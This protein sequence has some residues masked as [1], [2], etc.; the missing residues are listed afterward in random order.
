MKRRWPLFLCFACWLIVL[1]FPALRQMLF[2]Q[3]SGRSEVF[4]PWTHGPFT[5]GTLP[6]AF[7]SLWSSN[8]MQVKERFPDDPRV[9]A[10]AIEEG[11]G[12]RDNDTRALLKDYDALIRRFPQ[13]NWLIARRLIRTIEWMKLNRMGGEFSD[14]FVENNRAKGIPSPERYKEPPNYTPK[15]LEDALEIA[16]LGAEREPDNAFYDWLQFYLLMMNWRDKEAWPL[17]ARGSHKKD[18]NMHG[19]EW[20]K[21]RIA[22][23]E[24]ELGR[25]LL[26]EEKL[27]VGGSTPNSIFS[28]ERALGRIVEWEGLKAGRRRGDHSEALQIYTDM[29]RLQALHAKRSYSIIES[30]VAQALLSLALDVEGKAVRK[31][32]TSQQ[33]ESAEYR[34]RIS[35]RKFA[36]YATKHGRPDLADEITH[37]R[38]A[39]GKQQDLVRIQVRSGN[40][41]NGLT[42]RPLINSITLWWASEILLL[43][44]TLL[45]TLWLGLIAVVR[46]LGL[47]APSISLRDLVL[48]TL[49]STLMAVCC[50]IIPL[51]GG[52]GWHTTY[53]MG[54]S[55]VLG[56]GVK[57]QGENL[58]TL[59]LC[60]VIMPPLIASWWC[61]RVTQQRAARLTQKNSAHLPSR[62][63]E[64]L[65]T[66][67]FAPYVMNFAMLVMATGTLAWWLLVMLKNGEDL[68][69]PDTSGLFGE[70]L[71][72][73]TIT[74]IHPLW[75]LASFAVVLLAARLRP[76][77]NALP[78][79]KPLVA[80]RLHWLHQTL[81]ALLVTGSVSYLLLFALSLPQRA[82]A[83]AQ[84][85]QLI[86]RGELALAREK[87]ARDTGTQKQ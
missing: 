31:D 85:N 54:S 2:I 43:L 15:E 34:A 62:W 61:G 65:R 51:M 13:E 45:L 49:T 39:S 14:P 68:P 8:P 57:E 80:Y 81:G 25:P 64:Q 53:G 84:M 63:R 42:V 40:Y 44:L 16:R 21:A 7:G 66:I 19:R 79:D 60:G 22:L 17:L 5:Y 70:P 47:P 33:W 28:K 1:L 83:D 41:Y 73:I 48:T 30:L 86:Q 12:Y 77:F 27:S 29:A 75:P 55:D 87:I 58:S 78:Q 10:I 36:R 35:A 74:P 71:P 11:R 37:L 56:Q 67:R 6:F 59:L 26:W 76:L 46:A 38:I 3:L 82:I 18:Y 4:R 24:M 50:F 20:V 32:M 72:P 9:S 52:L 23:L 69:L